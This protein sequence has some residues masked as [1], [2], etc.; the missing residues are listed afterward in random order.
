MYFN[1]MQQ[2]QKMIQQKLAKD[3]GMWVQKF[4]EISKM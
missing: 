4:Q 3:L 1:V 2:Q